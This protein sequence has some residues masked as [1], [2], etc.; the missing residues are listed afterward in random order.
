M[1]L[2]DTSQTKRARIGTS[3]SQTSASASHLVSP[4]SAAPTYDLLHTCR[5]RL[6]T[7]F[8]DTL[9]AIPWWTRWPDHWTAGYMSQHAAVLG[10]WERPGTTRQTRHPCAYRRRRASCRVRARPQ[11]PTPPP[12]TRR[13][14]LHPPSR[15][16]QPRR[17]LPSPLYTPM[18]SRH[19]ATATTKHPLPASSRRRRCRHPRASRYTTSPRSPTSGGTPSRI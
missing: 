12:P 4:D 3:Q 19:I 9:S 16:P 15:Q 7:L 2:P 5:L 1:W 13:P 17:P 10:M 8:R 18:S 11:M 6:L 14:R